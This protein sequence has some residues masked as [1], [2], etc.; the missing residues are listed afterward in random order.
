LF[1]LLSLADLSSL[2]LSFALSFNLPESVF[3]L[4]HRL[5]RSSYRFSDRSSFRLFA[6]S[7]RGMLAKHAFNSSRDDSFA[8]RLFIASRPAIRKH[9]SVPSSPAF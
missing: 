9:P 7:S 6:I 8:F 5:R 4:G 3:F 2:P 1:R